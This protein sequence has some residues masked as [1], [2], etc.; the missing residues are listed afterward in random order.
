MSVL[1]SKHQ[2]RREQQDSPVRERRDLRGWLSIQ[3][4]AAD[5]R[6]QDVP[7]DE[8][9]C[10]DFKVWGFTRSPVRVNGIAC[11]TIQVVTKNSAGRKR[12]E[13]FLCILEDGELGVETEGKETSVC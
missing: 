5:D 4:G 8:T 2:Q 10:A 6:L 13:E 3:R 7:R 9:V 1:R 11:E 12:V